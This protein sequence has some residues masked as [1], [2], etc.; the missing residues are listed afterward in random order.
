MLHF[1]VSPP[2]HTRELLYGHIAL[3]PDQE[4][5]L[6]ETP[7]CTP[8]HTFD[9]PTKGECTYVGE[10]V[11]GRIL[12]EGR[13]GPWVVGTED[14]VMSILREAMLIE[15]GDLPPENQVH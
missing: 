1:Y 9:H 6:V 7:P 12:V 2:P 8:D 3:D 10:G 14:E 11:A 13:G 4:P 5:F 15:D